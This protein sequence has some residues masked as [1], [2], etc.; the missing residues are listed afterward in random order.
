MRSEM[1]RGSYLFHLHTTRTDSSL[2]VDDHFQFALRAGVDRLLFLEHIRR[3]P[4]YDV[5][6][7]AREVSMHSETSG[8]SAFLG[9]ETKLLA[10]GTLDIDD[11]A[12][13][14]ASV[15]GIAE[16]GFPDDEH[17]LVTAFAKVIERYAERSRT[18]VWVHPGLWFLRHR[19][20]PDAEPGYREMIA[21]AHEAGVLLERNLRYNLLT[22]SQAAL[23]P[24]GDIVLG[25]DAH[26]LKDL[27]RWQASLPRS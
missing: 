24:S 5:V 13:E 9:F 23:L 3:S 17:L 1:F 26:S 8:V 27:E 6:G 7:L 10:D 11:Q 4:T 16:H 18:F 21:C 15:I 2:T 19:R 12:L 22:E 25:A 14:L 20:P